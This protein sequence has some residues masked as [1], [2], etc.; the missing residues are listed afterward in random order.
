MKYN[1]HLEKEYNK[2]YDTHFKVPSI[3]REDSKI[4]TLVNL[5]GSNK[6]VLDVGCSTGYLCY[7]L[8]KKGNSVVG[9][10][11]IKSAIDTAV[12]SGLD[13]RHCNIEND[14]IPLKSEELFDVII[15]SEIIEHFIDPLQVIN[16]LTKY[17]NRGGVVIVS[18]PNIAYIQYR[19][20][21]LLG[22]LPDFCEFRNK[23]FERPYNFQ[24]K[25]LFTYK[26]LEDTLNM[27]NLGV[28]KKTSHVAY[29]NKFESFFNIF[30][31]ILPKLFVKNMVFVC[32]K[33]I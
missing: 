21:L 4:T 28:I 1:S 22:R 27:A 16:T 10:D 26:V 33:N 7:F 11:F 24:H 15:L 17:L 23:F 30:E 8:G 12:E 31:F 3:P 13:C 25:S 18:T 19:F 5:V 2:Y 29:K 32:K 14:D 6:T 9:I 20:E